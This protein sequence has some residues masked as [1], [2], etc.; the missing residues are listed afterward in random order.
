MSER[1]YVQQ[2]LDSLNATTNLE[3][4]LADLYALLALVLGRNTTLEDVHDAGSIWRNRAKL[5]H[6]SLM[7]FDRLAVEVQGLDRLYMAAIHAAADEV[8]G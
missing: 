8:A 3:S 4:G 1:N 7:P 6:K 5:D 2:V